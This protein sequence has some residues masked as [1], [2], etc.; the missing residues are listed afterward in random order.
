MTRSF[1]ALAV[2][3]AV[4]GTG[5]TEIARS[6]S[7]PMPPFRV[8]AHGPGL[9][10]SRGGVAVDVTSGD[11]RLARY[12]L[13]LDAVRVYDAA[14]V[15]I[16]RVRVS[17]SGFDIVARDGAVVGT[18]T[19]DAD[20]ADV[21]FGDDTWG[22]DCDDLGCSVLGDDRVVTVPGSP[23]GNSRD[24]DRTWALADADGRLV[25]TAGDREHG[26][27]ATRWS[28]PALT[29]LVIDAEWGLDG[30]D[31]TLVSGAVAFAVEHV[32]TESMNADVADADD[33]DDV[34]PTEGAE[35]SGE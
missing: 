35:G 15:Q 16:G 6:A 4:L 18:V 19:L 30:I 28:T 29:V 13:G 9:D 24:G 34:A 1:A 7:P 10:P 8:E 5:C 23:E 2:S 32:W 11:E 20:G 14:A 26:V 3:F 25:A 31:D 27:R 22:V 17:P 21:A 33:A 12:R